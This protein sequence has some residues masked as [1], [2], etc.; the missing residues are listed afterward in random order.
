[1]GTS[2]RRWR[3][4]SSE[5]VDPIPTDARSMPH[6]ARSSVTRSSVLSALVFAVVTA[7]SPARAQIPIGSPLAV[8]RTARERTPRWATGSGH[9]AGCG[10]RGTPRPHAVE[11]TLLAPSVTC[12]TPCSSRDEKSSPIC[13][14][15]GG[16]RL[17]QARRHAESFVLTVRG[18]H[19]C[20]V[21]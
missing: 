5:R 17:A 10:R 11:H 8:R 6:D 13:H 2:E 1:R 18:R 14:R 20:V 12:L 19:F 4:L 7:A 15:R 16:L 3:R 9:D 21:G